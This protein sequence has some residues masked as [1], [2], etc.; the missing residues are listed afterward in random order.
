MAI[1]TEKQVAI[2]FEKLQESSLKYKPLQ[3]ELLDHLCCGTEQNLE[4]NMS[5]QQAMESSFESFSQGEFKVIEQKTLLLIR[6]KYFIMKKLPILVF[7]VLILSV[8]I[9]KAVQEPNEP[10][11]IFP[12]LGNFKVHSPFGKRVHPLLKVKK[13]HRGIDII[14][15]LGT[16]VLATSDGVVVLASD[17]K[18]S[19]L[20]IQI[21][22]DD[23]YES[24]YCHLSRIDVKVGQEIKK[25]DVIGAVGSTGNSVGP[26]LH[27]EVLCKGEYVNPGEYFQP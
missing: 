15:P 5:F 13:L 25:G 26:H 20:K 10:P 3:E 17:Q 18:G 21:K 2:I 12:M 7:L 1:L 16:E 23:I 4:Q 11:S 9:S 27:Y 22:H 24:A 19:G 6:S 14:A 8:S